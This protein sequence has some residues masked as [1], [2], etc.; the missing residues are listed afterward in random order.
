MNDQ[1]KAYLFALT[2]VAIWSTV[3]TAFKIALGYLDPYT[4][5]FIA[6]C[7]SSLSLLIVVSLNGGISRVRNLPPLRL[8]KFCILGTLNPV[9]YYVVLFNAYDLLKAQEAQ[10]LNYT[11]PMIMGLLSIVFLKERLRALNI[12]ALFL[13]F[14]GVMVISTKG[15]LFSDVPN[16]MGVVL[17]LS[18]GILWSIYWIAMLKERRDRDVVMLVSFVSSIPI[19]AVI[20]LIAGGPTITGI[21]PI[22]AAIYVGIF[23]MGVTFFL[24]MRAL[25][26]SSNTTRITSLIYLG[27]FLS[28]VFINLILGE[29]I[30]LTTLAGLVLITAGIALH[31][32]A[33]VPPSMK[34]KADR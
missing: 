30:L 34:V 31:S 29:K 1:G 11:W 28:L 18:S 32:W 23:E 17:A 10:P 20:A 22:G 24:W 14:A 27:P 16:A 21:I 15:F 12:A 5:L 13:G 33:R 25:T 6:T 26:L 8:L 19:L 2:A 4:L 3:A 9:L 7:A